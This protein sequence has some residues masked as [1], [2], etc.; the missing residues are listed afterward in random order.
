MRN[1]SESDLL[2]S[3]LTLAEKGLEARVEVP[4]LVR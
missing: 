3:E 1:T 2:Q 4:L